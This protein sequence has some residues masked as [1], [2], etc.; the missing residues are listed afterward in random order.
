MSIITDKQVK[1]NRPDIII[2][3]S[4]K[5]VFMRISLTIPVC[6][7]IFRKVSAIMRKN[8]ELDIELR[9]YWNLAEIKTV[10]IVYGA[11]GT[12]RGSI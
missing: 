4:K 7:H 12:I 5:R 10:P 2:H 9:K 1:C 6:T 3:N 8:R 11:L